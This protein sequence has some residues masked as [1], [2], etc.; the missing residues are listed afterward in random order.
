MLIYWL[1]LPTFVYYLNFARTLTSTASQPFPVV[2]L[3]DF[4]NVYHWQ[5]LFA[6]LLRCSSIFAASSCVRYCVY[7]NFGLYGAPSYTVLWFSCTTAT[8]CWLRDSGELEK[9]EFYSNEGVT[10]RKLLHSRM[11][12]SSSATKS[13]IKIIFPLCTNFNF[14]SS[15]SNCCCFFGAI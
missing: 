10:Q 12:F 3:C 4:S 14:F 13:D 11:Q 2:P 1:S 9:I 7:A 15:P 8:C 6:A 5:S